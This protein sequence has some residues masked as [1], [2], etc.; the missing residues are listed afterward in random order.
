MSMVQQ[1]PKLAHIKPEA[2]VKKRTN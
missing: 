2:L 1:N